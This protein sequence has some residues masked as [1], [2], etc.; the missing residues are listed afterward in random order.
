MYN[1][2]KQLFDAHESATEFVFS[3]FICGRLSFGIEAYPS[4]D[5]RLKNNERISD[6]CFFIINYKNFINNMKIVI[7]YDVIYL[8]FQKIYEK[9]TLFNIKFQK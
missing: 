1:G 6:I 5:V 7:Y 3:C 9:S 2:P 8:N 4:P